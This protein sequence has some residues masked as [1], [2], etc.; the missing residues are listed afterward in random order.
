MSAWE[1]RS[2]RI[3]DRIRNREIRERLYKGYKER[4]WMLPEG[5]GNLKVIKEI[6]ALRKF[7]FQETEK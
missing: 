3:M 2:V 6:V 1:G 4:S 5:K 7:K